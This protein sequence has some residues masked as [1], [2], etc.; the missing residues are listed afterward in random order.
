MNIVGHQIHGKQAIGTGYTYVLAGNGVFIIAGSRHII[1]G[2]P[3]ASVK[4]RGLESRGVCF[5]L[6]TVKDIMEAR[7]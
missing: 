6:G 2:V 5:D 3:V 4:I 1:A 7:I